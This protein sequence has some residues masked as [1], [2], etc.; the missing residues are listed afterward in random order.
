MDQI[1][2][3]NR[4]AAQHGERLKK[5]RDELKRL[6]LD[7]YVVAHTDEHKSEYT[8]EYAQRL[9]WL[10]GFT[11]SAGQVVVLNG[12]AAIFIDGRYTLQARD[13]VD[14]ATYEFLHL[15]DNPPR[16]WIVSEV[17][18]GGRIGYDPW[19]HSITWVEEM[20]AALGKKG[21][22]LVA[23]EANPI[24]AIWTGQPAPSIR[25]AEPHALEFAGETS[26]SKRQRLAAKIAEAGA[27]AAVF[28][29]LDS[30]AW[31]FN[32][33][34]ADVEHSP[35]VLAFAILNRDAT[36]ELFIDPRKVTGDLKAHLGPDI[37][38][39][40][41]TAFKT[42][43]E[44]LGKTAKT[45]LVDANSAAAAVFNI[46]EDSGADITR[47][48][49][50]CQHPKALKNETELEGAR[51]AHRRDGAALTRFLSWIIEN[52]PKG[53]IDEIAASDKLEAMRR[54][55]NLFRDLSFGTISGAGP[56]G[57]I[58]HYSAKP[59]T[60]RKI[61][62]GMLYL[63]DSGA[64][65]PDGTT[66]V[67]R[68]VAIGTPGLE[69]IDRFTRV[70]KGHIAVATARFPKGTTGAQLDTLARMALWQEGYNYDHGTGHGVGSYLSVH[71]GPQNISKSGTA[72]AL[73]P[74]MILSNEPGYYKAGHYGIRI[75][76]L[77]V[78]R[79]ATGVKGDIPVY[80][81]EV[82][83]LAPIDTRL[84]DRA[85]LTDAEAEWLNR[86]HARV[87]EVLTPEVDAATAKWLA[88][89]TAPI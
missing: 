24:D 59:E 47:Q 34:G 19:L 28:T 83:T 36:A 40:P 76:N 4:P 10:S 45:V 88:E 51:A 7:G 64:Q 1:A 68:T 29:S 43:L 42:G 16:D 86:Y 30:I 32:I 63:V 65:Y 13:E 49:D 50:L 5:L 60:A 39:H 62:A 14:A 87:R 80:E 89:A 74:G 41:K 18:K 46:L 33:R 21:A 85:L 11:G 73:E 56:N 77:L 48:G 22:D 58:V 38:R 15:I 61:E 79:E 84:I 72:A 17:K 75:E 67:T 71:E 26:L 3:A 66:D 52:G 57:A 69:E 53:G 27:D 35:L 54:E 78:V 55:N 9:T 70:L 44:A 12:K 23:V 31:L 20:K 8:P 37:R 25:P 6:N 2:K 81:F 82:L